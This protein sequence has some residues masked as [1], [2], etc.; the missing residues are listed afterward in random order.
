VIF[1]ELLTHGLKPFTGR[2]D[3]ELRTMICR[4]DMLRIPE[5]FSVP[6]MCAKLLSRMLEKDPGRRHTAESAVQEAKNIRQYL[7][8]DSFRIY[9]REN[10][11]KLRILVAVIIACIRIRKGGEYHRKRKH[12][13]WDIL[14]KTI[15]KDN[16]DHHHVMELDHLQPTL[17]GSPPISLKNMMHPLESGRE[18]EK[19]PVSP[20][21]KELINARPSSAIQ[22]L[23]NLMKH[24]HNKE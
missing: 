22:H 16:E 9:P 15:E 19:C 14:T 18:E 11:R 1:Y 10:P 21:T 5:R 20:R 8:N 13:V 17:S 24:V 23:Q 12:L 4:K 7:R 2:T 6:G 3:D